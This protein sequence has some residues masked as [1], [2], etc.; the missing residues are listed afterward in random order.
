MSDSV[1]GVPV[2]Y[3]ICIK[4][5]DIRKKVI[6]LLQDALYDAGRFQNSR[7]YTLTYIEDVPILT[8][9]G[10]ILTVL[11]GPPEKEMLW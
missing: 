2:Q 11:S 7:L 5:P 3:M 9:R 8:Q 6:D 10:F 4:D 1:K